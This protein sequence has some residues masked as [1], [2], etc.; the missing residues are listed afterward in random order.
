MKMIINHLQI[1]KAKIAKNYFYDLFLLI[2]TFKR[3]R[4]AGASRSRSPNQIGMKRL[5]ILVYVVIT[6]KNESIFL[7]NSLEENHLLGGEKA[8]VDL[9]EERDLLHFLSIAL[10]VLE[11]ESNKE[12]F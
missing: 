2:L 8:Q 6:M 9:P 4:R 11:I 12:S 3:V 5:I 1:R 7:L 10:I